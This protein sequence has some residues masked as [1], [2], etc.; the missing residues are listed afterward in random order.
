MTPL[1]WRHNERDVVLNHR[2]LYCLLNRFFGRRSKKTSKLHGTDR[3]EGNS[4]VTGECPSQ[5]ASN[6]EN[7][8][9]WWR[10]M[11]RSSKIVTDIPRDLTALW[12]LN[13]T[14]RGRVTHICVGNLTIIGADNGLSPGRR[15]AITWTNVGILLIGPLGTNFS[16]ILIGIHTVSFKKIHLKMSSAKWRPFCFGLNVLSNVTSRLTG[17]S[18]HFNSHPGSFLR[19]PAGWNLVGFS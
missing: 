2:R 4:P 5:R 10:H 14:H 11:A 6:A 1:K 8:T 18:V 3:C 7:V 12:V 16:E 13:S 15:Q 19:Q 17:E 9:S